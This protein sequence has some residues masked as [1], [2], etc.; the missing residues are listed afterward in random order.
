ME[1]GLRQSLTVNV[2]W[3]GYKTDCLFVKKERKGIS[4]SL[5]NR[6]QDPGDEYSRE[7]MQPSPEVHSLTLLF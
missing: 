1:G 2:P 5:V 4:R 3:C 6:A 7:T